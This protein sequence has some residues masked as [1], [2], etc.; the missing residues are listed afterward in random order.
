MSSEF[1]Q[2]KSIFEERLVVQK[3]K[4]QIGV[5]DLKGNTII[6]PKYEEINIY[7]KQATFLQK[8]TEK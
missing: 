4:K 2:Q 3:D 6:E 1:Q 8:A 5:I 7:Q